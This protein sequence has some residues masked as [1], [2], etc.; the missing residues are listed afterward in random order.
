M[1]GYAFANFGYSSETEGELRHKMGNSFWDSFKIRQKIKNKN[2]PWPGIEP[3][4][5]QY[6]WFSAAGRSGYFDF[7]SNWA[8]KAVRRSLRG[9]LYQQANQAIL[10]FTA[11]GPK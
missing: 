3:G 7:D 10:I 1:E 8:K 9:A 4:T 5:L 2:L 11:V 6:V